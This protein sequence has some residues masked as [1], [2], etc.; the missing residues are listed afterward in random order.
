MGQSLSDTVIPSIMFQ[1]WNDHIDSWRKLSNLSVTDVANMFASY[2]IAVHMIGK[3]QS[4]PEC[5]PTSFYTMCDVSNKK[6]MMCHFFCSPP[7]PSVEDS[8]DLTTPT[9]ITTP[10]RNDYFDNASDTRLSNVDVAMQIMDFFL[11]CNCKLYTVELLALSSEVYSEIESQFSG[12]IDNPIIVF[13]ELKDSSKHL[14][15][16]AYKRSM[17]TY[18]DA[19]KKRSAGAYEL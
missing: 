10:P 3:F 2:D 1:H 15:L 12:D 4:Q 14:L 11:W 8:A 17:R 6:L 13:D 16:D 5:S 18:D 19:E 7:P 9:P